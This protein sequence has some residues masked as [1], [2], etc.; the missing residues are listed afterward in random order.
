VLRGRGFSMR[1]ILIERIVL[2]NK[3][4]KM[5]GVITKRARG[6]VRAKRAPTEADA[7]RSCKLTS[8]YIFFREH[9]LVAAFHIPP[10]L[11]QSAAFFAVATSPANAGPVKASAKAIARAEIRAFM[12]FLLTM[13][14]TL[15]PP[16]NALSGASVPRLRRPAAPRARAKGGRRSFLREGARVDCACRFRW[17]FAPSR[18]RNQAPPRRIRQ[19]I[20]RD[21]FFSGQAKICFQA[22]YLDSGL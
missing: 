13:E 14:L 21:I 9:V 4:Q 11:A 15:P 20:H 22:F 19:V 16:T 10:A 6:I 17:L 2:S 1:A 3:V 7:L 18:R 5:A 8:S 12:A